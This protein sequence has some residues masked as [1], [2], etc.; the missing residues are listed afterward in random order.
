MS[1]AVYCIAVVYI[2]HRTVC[3]ADKIVLQS[4]VLITRQQQPAYIEYERNWHFSE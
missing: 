2:K 4:N 3:S 1:T